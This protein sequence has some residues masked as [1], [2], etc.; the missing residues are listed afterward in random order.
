MQIGTVTDLGQNLCESVV[1]V[2]DVAVS[3]K[4]VTPD[5]AV[6]S[7]DGRRFGRRPAKTGRDVGTA[8]H[9]AM[10][11]VARLVWNSSR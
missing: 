11:Q 5:D 7:D 10:P 9:K 2:H 1:L 3:V 8:N 4:H 6:A